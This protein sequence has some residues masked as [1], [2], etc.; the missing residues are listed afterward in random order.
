[1]TLAW[2]DQSLGRREV[3][4]PP[5]LRLIKKPSP[6][7]VK[8]N[9]NLPEKEILN[10]WRNISFHSSLEKNYF[11]IFHSSLE[12]ILK[13]LCFNLLIHEH[14]CLAIC[15]QISAILKAHFSLTFPF[16]KKFKL[17]CWC[18]INYYSEKN[19]FCIFF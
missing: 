11:I 12:I 14:M 15:L 5:W 9:I 19:D 18:W 17:N 2:G 8:W 13:E 1:M 4:R 7:R 6:D 16:A 10:N 3:I